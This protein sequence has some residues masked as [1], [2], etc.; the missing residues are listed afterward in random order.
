MGISPNELPWW[1]WLLST[2]VAVAV[3]R[4]AAAICESDHPTAGCLGLLLGISAGIA[5]TVCFLIAVIRFVK[6]VWID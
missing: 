2:I 4:I 6:W 3:V 1:G 5:A